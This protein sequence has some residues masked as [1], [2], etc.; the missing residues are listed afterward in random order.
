MKVF[1]EL[2]SYNRKERKGLTQRTQSEN[3]GNILFAI[4]A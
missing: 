3:A 4:L 1:E 2:K